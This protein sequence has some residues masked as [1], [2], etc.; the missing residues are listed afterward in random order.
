MFHSISLPASLQALY[1]APHFRKV[2][3]DEQYV[4]DNL[5]DLLQQENLRVQIL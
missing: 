3:V 4:R 2:V 5:G 1:P